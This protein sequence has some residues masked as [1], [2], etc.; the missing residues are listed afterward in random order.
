MTLTWVFLNSSQNDIMIKFCVQQLS[1]QRLKLIMP[2]HAQGIQFE[3]LA[4]DWGV[5]KY[6]IDGYFGEGCMCSR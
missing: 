3:R 2:C 1:A 5:V 4:I 6:P